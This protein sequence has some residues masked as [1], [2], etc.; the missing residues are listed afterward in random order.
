MKIQKIVNAQG[1]WAKIG[2]DFRDG[3]LIKIM[4]EGQIIE[5]EFGPR[6]VF[7]VAFRE[8][9]GSKN[10]SFNQTSLNNLVDGYGDDT[11]NWTEKK[12]RVFV[13]K[14]MVQNK[15]RNIA[16]LTPEDWTMTEDGQ[17]V[18]PGKK[19]E[20]TQ[21]EPGPEQVEYPEEKINPGDIPF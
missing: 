9:E 13:I 3:D 7:K 5:G 4:D 17:F 21:T 19:T 2:E 15:L 20:E 6:K 12:V 10:L 14:Q 11:K 8:K 18:A 16:Y 1:D